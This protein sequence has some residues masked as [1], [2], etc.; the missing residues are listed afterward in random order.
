M[1]KQAYEAWRNVK[2]PKAT[3]TRPKT[4][5]P[6]I[7]LPTPKNKTTKGDAEKKIEWT[8]KKETPKNA[9][10]LGDAARRDENTKHAE[11]RARQVMRRVTEDK[12]TGNTGKG[13][14]GMVAN[15]EDWAR[16]ENARRTLPEGHKLRADITRWQDGLH[17]RNTKLA[18]KVGALEYDE[19]SGEWRK[20]GE[21]AYKT[22]GTPERPLA[23]PK[24][25]AGQ[26]IGLA[27]SSIGKNIKGMLPALVETSQQTAEN[28][29][30]DSKN[31]KLVDLQSE[32]ESLRG[33]LTTVPFETAGDTPEYKKKTARYQAVLKLIEDADTDTAVDQDKFG[34]KMMRESAADAAKATEGMEGAGKFVADTGISIANSAVT[35]PT[36]AINPV[37]PL[38]LM[39]TQAAARKTVELNAHGIA[40]DEALGRGIVSGAIEAATEKVPVDTLLDV[41]KAGGKGALKNMMKQ[42][43]IEATEESASY[44]ANFLADKAANDP[45]AQFSLQELGLNAAGGALSGGIMA[46]GGTVVGKAMHRAGN[47]QSARKTSG[48][49]LPSAAQNV[50]PAAAQAIPPVATRPVEQT[51]QPVEQSTRPVEQVPRPAQPIARPVEQITPPVEQII[52]PQTTRVEQK[53][54]EVRTMSNTPH[55]DVTGYTLSPDAV[56]LGNSIAQSADPV[57]ELQALK[58]VYQP[59]Y[60]RAIQSA[61]EYVSNYKPQGVVVVGAD[62]YKRG[63]YRASQ[64]E[65]WY[66]EF[67]KKNGRA[68]RK[69]DIAQIAQ[70]LVAA[71][72]DGSMFGFHARSKQ[73]LEAIDELQGRVFNRDGF[74]GFTENA[75][76]DV[77]AVYDMD[78]DQVGKV[79]ADATTGAAP[80]G[81][82][83]YTRMANEYGT[84]APGENPTRM[85]DIP[86][87]T[88][89]SDRVSRFTR[90]MMEAEATPESMIADFENLVETGQASYEPRKNKRDLENA[91]SYIEQNGYDRALQAWD[92]KLSSKGEVSADDLIRAQIMYAAAAK[93]GDTQT[94]M[95]LAGQMAAEYT[96][97]GQ[98]VQSARIL[99]NATPEGRLYYIKRSID[100]L[101]KD[102]DGKRGE[103]SPAIQLD[104][105]LARGVLDATNEAE[106]T[107]A[108][109]ALMK[110][111]AQQ[112]PGTWADKINAWRYLSMLGNPRTHI[113]NILG[114][115]MMS[116]PVSVKNKVGATLETALVRDGERTKSFLPADRATQDFAKADAVEMMEVLKGGGK[117]NPTDIIRDYQDP[118]SPKSL[119]GRA[120]NKASKENSNALDAEDAIFLGRHYRNAL[121]GYMKANN[122]TASD[123][124]NDLGAATNALE[125]ART[126]AINEAQKATFR[127][128]SKFA[129]ALARMEKQNAGTKLAIGGLVP[130]KK[131]PVNI[132]KRGVEYSP[133]GFIKL[134]KE[135]AFDLRD[136]TKTKTDAIDTAASAITGTGLMAVGAFLAKSD[137]L[138]GSGE[139]EKKER[140][141]SGAEGIQNYS[142]NLGELTYTVDWTAP[143]SLPIFMGV[144]LWDALNE[145]G[146]DDETA[147]NT[148]VSSIMNLVEPVF[149]LTML[150][151]V[152]GLMT[153]AMYGDTGNPIGDAIGNTVS[154][155][156]GQFVPTALGQIAR[157]VDDTRRTPYK[158]NEITGMRGVD[159]WLQRQQAKIPGASKN[160]A[161]Y[162]DVFGRTSTEPNTAMR[163]FQNFVSPGYVARKN[164]DDVT[165]GLRAL[166]RET[167][168]SSVLLGNARA[169][170][171]A[172]DKDIKLDQEKY[173][174]FVQTRGN[175]IQAGLSDLFKSDTY[176]QMSD[177]DKIDVV[178][179]IYL[180]ANSHAK[181]TVSAYEMND[182]QKRAQDSGLPLGTYYA[183]KQQLSALSKPELKDPDARWKVTESILT[184]DTLKREDKSKLMESLVIADIGED[185]TA[186]YN[187]KFKAVMNP[188]TFIRLRG[189]YSKISKQFDGEDNAAGKRQAAWIEY[190]DKTNMEPSIRTVVEDG[191]KF[192]Q[193]IPAKPESSSYAMLARYGGKNEQAHSSALE[194][195]GLSIDDYQAAKEYKSGLTGD[196]QKE[197][198]IAWMRGQGWTSA[199]ISAAGSA[200]GYKMSSSSGSSSLLPKLPAKPKL[201]KL[202]LP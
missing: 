16:L 168:D 26:R 106:L 18:A 149:S 181:S 158:N 138:N 154:S 123:M 82:D 175:T 193:M 169:E 157:T 66:R 155:Y 200:M 64:N 21:R 143:A 72:E 104:D 198:V 42:A 31:Q 85:V 182:A 191:I 13:K 156:A 29:R 189:E 46:G 94:A 129:D 50:A 68:P 35:L 60:D 192:W 73:I 57:G 76:G 180:H 33:W 184:D 140:L 40:P 47:A 43:G 166:Y 2:L 178:Q 148:A 102:L 105:T 109:D 22:K 194:N 51:T 133:A 8:K 108:A 103:N 10:R 3:V 101:Q 7:G 61:S 114:N 56:K 160:L 112:I 96:K 165:E 187:D 93:A 53:A 128:A 59:A 89:G 111:V 136:G 131:T 44:I 77:Q 84:I 15:S 202:K 48:V 24:P 118:F 6:S 38:A 23:E 90:T 201:P 80:A 1:A 20:D 32:A 121:A 132:V 179:K 122:L 12:K 164:S 4:G 99:K 199:Q 188:E 120:L 97:A 174:K 150:D 107:A 37:V 69:S 17:Q 139:D 55:Y 81:F 127:D 116:A 92:E 135:I 25:T 159:Q 49:K 153:G 141:L 125:R 83:P 186:K 95:R 91:V 100:N 119:L 79:Q 74:T 130:F 163:A 162:M 71:D 27:A 39:G 144:E 124:R 167:G 86:Q 88:D 45:E 115:I 70:E 134:A 161:P 170:F 151:G 67:Y 98:K 171:R 9:P 75:Q 117:Y 11:E 34:Q 195:S 146:E 41:V 172:D 176:K 58:E 185:A 63:G 177:A 78:V 126:Y 19:P 65:P 196:G 14:K 54:P 137:V 113:R 30:L 173:V 145:D 152:Q 62:E 147:L 197:R 5:D 87:S 183:Y 110:D 52:P 190:L 28:V 36:A 142:L